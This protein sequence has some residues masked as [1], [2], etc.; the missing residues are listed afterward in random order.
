M[1]TIDYTPKTP[2]LIT[3]GASGIGKASAVALAEVGRDVVLWDLD[4]DK[5]TQVANQ[6]S[7]THQV[8]AY[9]M[10]VD[11]REVL[12]IPV[13]LEQSR[14]KIGKA[15]GGLVHA[16]GVSGSAF[17]EDI[18]L[19][20]W[21]RTIDTNLQPQIFLVQ[22]LLEDLKT[23]PN[24]A[25]VGIASINGT[26]GNAGNPA[27]S[28]AKSGLLGLNRALA[29]SLGSYGIRIN[30]VSPGQIF[31]PMLQPI[32]DSVDGL[33]KQF[34]ERIFLGRIGKPEEIAN[35]VRFLMSDQA[36]Y[37]TGAELVVDG[38]NIPSQH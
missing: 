34:E 11:V 7:Q 30:S 22:G 28:A 15:F 31:T 4:G 9:G 17:L 6:I 29:D 19:Q 20:D 8:Q 18:T 2:V 37:I 33:Q 10:A 38:G 16:A 3:G 12:N 26:L 13:A 27:Y 5:V 25:I 36:S 1:A 21:Q 24:A 14:E 23:T 32:L 35:A